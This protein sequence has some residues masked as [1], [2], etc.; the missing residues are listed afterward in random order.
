M[1]ELGQEVFYVC[2]LRLAPFE[3]PYRH[4]VY[5]AKKSVTGIKIEKDSGDVLYTAGK[6]SE[7]IFKETEDGFKSVT[8]PNKPV[9]LSYD[10]AAKEK[11]VWIEFEKKRIAEA[12]NCV[13]SDETES[14]DNK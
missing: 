14:E 12:E 11:A 8:K 2:R 6:N 7:L 4:K 5:I 1:L 13:E 10:D 3:K 9:F